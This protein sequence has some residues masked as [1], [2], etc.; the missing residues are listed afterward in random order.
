MIPLNDT[1]RFVR[2]LGRFFRRFIGVPSGGLFGDSSLQGE[3]FYFPPNCIVIHYRKMASV[4]EII[5]Q[6]KSETKTDG[7]NK[8]GPK[9]A[10][11]RPRNLHIDVKEIARYA[12]DIYV[13]IKTI[14]T[15]RA[16]GVISVIHF[17]SGRCQLCIICI[18][19]LILT[20]YTSTDSNAH[21]KK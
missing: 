1:W 9:H 13:K 17:F 7:Q 6:G 5:F 19:R 10:P 4:I 14:H 3:P 15:T 2:G 21:R 18:P 8:G 11:F 16:R 12:A 20:P